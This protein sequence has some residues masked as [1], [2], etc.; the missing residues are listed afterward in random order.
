MPE[1]ISTVLDANPKDIH[2][3]FNSAGSQI[4]P[5]GIIL[6]HFSNLSLGCW[7]STATY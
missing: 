1:A 4:R 6:V 2:T 3:P 5:P 7:V